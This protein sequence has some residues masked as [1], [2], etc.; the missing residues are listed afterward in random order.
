MP[1]GGVTFNH[2]RSRY[3]TSQDLR[4][5]IPDAKDATLHQIEHLFPIS[6]KPPNQNLVE[7][8]TR[9]IRIADNKQ[10]RMVL[11]SRIVD[12]S[13][14]QDEITVRQRPAAPSFERRARDT[15]GIFGIVG[16]QGAKIPGCHAADWSAFKDRTIPG[17]AAYPAAIDQPGIQPA[18]IGVEP[19][20]TC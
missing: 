18:A 16:V 4:R 7:P 1:L 5:R 11:T 13:P 9:K 14:D 3:R 20:S 2:R 19:K 10:D 6:P 12:T 17:F 8:D 15:L